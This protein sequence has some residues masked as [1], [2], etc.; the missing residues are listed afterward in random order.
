MDKK[1]MVMKVMIVMM[2]VMTLMRVRMTQMDGGSTKHSHCAVS[3]PFAFPSVIR[4]SSV[5]ILPF[6]A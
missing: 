3:F 2:M 1:M 4:L 5:N 6:E